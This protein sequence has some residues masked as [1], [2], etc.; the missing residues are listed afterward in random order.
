[1]STS[2]SNVFI[3]KVNELVSKNAGKDVLT[4]LMIKLGEYKC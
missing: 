2:L 3:P 4:D 1:M